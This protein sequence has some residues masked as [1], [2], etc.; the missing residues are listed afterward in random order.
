MIYYKVEVILVEYNVK[1]Y[2]NKI[3]FFLLVIK[4]E[5]FF[6]KKLIVFVIGSF[7]FLS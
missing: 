7:M 4:D 2:W 5:I 6:R 3:K 1:G